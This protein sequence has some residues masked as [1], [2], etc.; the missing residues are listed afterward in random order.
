VT[1][2]LRMVGRAMVLCAVAE[3]SMHASAPAA[4]DTRPILSVTLP[5][6]VLAPIGVTV[7]SISSMGDGVVAL[8]CR[9]VC[10]KPGGSG[11]VC[12]RGAA[13]SAV[14]RPLLTSDGPTNRQSPPRDE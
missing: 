11:A 13:A 12:N 9:A 4:R 14:G 7:K 1:S 3:V 5:R 6:V 2:A 10:A 8:S